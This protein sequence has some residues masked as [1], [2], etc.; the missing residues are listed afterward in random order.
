MQASSNGLEH[1]VSG[2]SGKSGKNR[3]G[4]KTFRRIAG[5]GIDSIPVH[6]PVSL[7][8][9]PRPE[10]WLLW[11]EGGRGGRREHRA[12]GSFSYCNLNCPQVEATLSTFVNYTTYATIP[13]YLVSLALYPVRVPTSPCSPVKTLRQTVASCVFDRCCATTTLQS[14]ASHCPP[15]PS[16][17]ACYS[18]AADISALLQPTSTPLHEPYS[19]L[20]HCQFAADGASFGSGEGN[21]LRAVRHP[22]SL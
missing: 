15:I 11:L 1:E 20:T 7:S 8:L 22:S 13:Y 5:T 14:P 17:A 18:Y 6:V 3:C 19:A 9:S 10:D 2:K 12:S 16:C 21:L 4:Q